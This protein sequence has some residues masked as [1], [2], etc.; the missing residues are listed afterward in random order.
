MISPSGRPTPASALQLVGLY[1]TAGI[2][3]GA[4]E[5]LVANLHGPASDLNSEILQ[6]VVACTCFGWCGLLVGTLV[7][8]LG[9]LT[10]VSVR[11]FALGFLAVSATSYVGFFYSVMFAIVIAL[12]AALVIVFSIRRNL[13]ALTSCLFVWL[14][15]L[16][17]LRPLY[18][19]KSIELVFSGSQTFLIFCLVAPTLYLGLSALLLRAFTGNQIRSRIIAG[20]QA[21]VAISKGQ[22]GVGSAQALNSLYEKCY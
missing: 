9:W 11:K 18:S 5:F 20:A 13:P 4:L 21:L 2:V 16:H 1:T 19:G 15:F 22:G 8:A 14:G 17:V 6:L 3:S 12:L 10:R 7:A